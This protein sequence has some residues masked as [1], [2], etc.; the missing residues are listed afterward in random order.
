MDLA[1]VVE[2]YV[3]RAAFANEPVSV[4][5]LADG[6]IVRELGGPNA[7]GGVTFVVG[8]WTP[9]SPPGT[10]PA[11]SLPVT[12]MIGLPRSRDL[13][14]A[15]DG[16]VDVAVQAWGRV[17]CTA[18][19]AVVGGTTTVGPGDDGISGVY[20]EDITWPTD[21]TPGA[22]ATTVVHVDA[23]NHIYDTDIYV[24]GADYTFGFD[25]IGSLVDF[26]SIATH[27]MGHVLGLGES[28]DPRATMYTAYSPGVAWRSLEQDDEAGVCALY[29][30]TGDALDCEARACPTS[31]QC[32][33]RDCVRL[34]DQRMTCSP[35][36]PGTLA[37][38]EGAGDNARCVAFS[39]GYGCGRPCTTT[40]DCGSGFTCQATTQAGD[41]QCVSSDG[42]ATAEDTCKTMADCNDPRDAGWICGAGACLGALASSDAGDAGQEAGSEP[43]LPYA[44]GGCS[45][46]GAAP[47][48][49]WLLLLASLLG[50]SAASWRA[51]SGRA[52]RRPCRTSP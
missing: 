8:K 35:C 20:F 19:R 12:M 32:V 31:F 42:C 2:T 5:K 25:G 24:N 38:C 39:S 47:E 36:E 15:E 18:F 29:P 41:Y 3:E 9:V 23:Q 7:R 45:A 21:L 26:R 52:P 46:G 4:T 51:S 40:Q 10:W 11:T 49:S 1:A 13:G 22:I 17:S 34:G 6:R 30:G 33:A 14:M 16:E 37:A 50:R 27:E 43:N 28:S 48:S 44:R